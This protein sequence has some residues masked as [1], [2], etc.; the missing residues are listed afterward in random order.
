M[1]SINYINN[2]S[3]D[4]FCNIFGNVFENTAWI[5]EKTYNLKPFL[6]FDTIEKSFLSIYDQCDNGQ[7]LEIFNSHPKLAVEKT[8][9]KNSLKEQRSTGL[10]ECTEQELN[11]F[12]NLNKEYK[13]K[14]NFP[15]I[16]AVS[17]KNK[18]EI[19]DIFKARVK[20]DLNTEFQE[21]KKQVKKIALIRIKEL[22]N[23]I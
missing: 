15:F 23:K 3:K 8:L 17:G 10:Y 11:E 16:I 14:F 7:F 21:A 19:L 22:F 20:N 5:S 18:K 2:L 12:S 9:T 6:D 13:N 1:N 4:E